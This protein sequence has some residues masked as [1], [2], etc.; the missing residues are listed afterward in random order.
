MRVSLLIWLIVLVFLAAW[1]ISTSAQS[2]NDVFNLL[3]QVLRRIPDARDQPPP[4]DQTARQPD[5]RVTPAEPAPR[6]QTPRYARADVRETQ[7]ILNQ[8]GYDAGPVDGAYGRR[9]RRAL[10]AFQQNEGLPA[11]GEISD[12]VLRRLET[13][14][15]PALAQGGCTAIRFARGTSAAEITGVAPAEGILCYTLATLSGQTASIEVIEGNNVIFLVPGLFDAADSYQ[16]TTEQKTYEVRVGQ[17][18]RAVAGVPFRIRVSV[19]GG[20]RGA[21]GEAKGPESSAGMAIAGVY[22]LQDG[23]DKLA[24]RETAGGGIEFAITS[25]QGGGHSCGAGGR[26]H[27]SPTGW[28]YEAD[29]SG[30]DH[31]RCAINFTYD[32]GV[33]LSVDR[34]ARCR[35]QCGARATLD[36]LLFPES[37]RLGR[38]AAPRVFE[39]PEF[40]NNA[41]C[42]SNSL[43]IS[44]APVP[45]RLR[46]G[47]VAGHG[48]AACGAGQQCLR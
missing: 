28:R 24:V 20:A 26:A 18:M 12:R 46:F 33:T 42:N 45:S 19:T 8:L 17:L 31:E 15:D 41:A 9:T 5:R 11:N 35:S 1:P 10:I 39:N 47:R 16:F 2:A 3:D 27:P 44:A 21:G 34:D 36:G 6:Y 48:G 29:M 38:L 30:A 14:G 37:S 40:F 13:V 43:A 4:V 23:A 32:H 25:W 7:R 22:C